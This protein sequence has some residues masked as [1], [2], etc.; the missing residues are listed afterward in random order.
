MFQDCLDGLQ[1]DPDVQAD[2]PVVDVFRVQLDHFLE[3]GD[4][5]AAGDLPHAGQARLGGKA[6]AVMVFVFLPF[7]LGRRPGADQ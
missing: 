5:A 4:L 2:G 1:E 6:G 3:V 7:V